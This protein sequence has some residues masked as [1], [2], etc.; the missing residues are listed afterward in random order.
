VLAGWERLPEGEKGHQG[1]ISW[2]EKVR[3]NRKRTTNLHT[4][5]GCE[6]GGGS[7]QGKET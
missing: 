4:P 1:I 2:E 7:V 6:E 5:V 3:R